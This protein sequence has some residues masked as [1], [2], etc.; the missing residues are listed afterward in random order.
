M[1]INKRIIKG[2]ALSALCIGFAFNSKAQSGYETA[3]ER[4]DAQHQDCMDNAENTTTCS[5]QYFASVDSLVDVVYKDVLKQ[6][7]TKEKTVLRTEQREWLTNK[8]I[9]FR[10]IEAAAKEEGKD[11]E[12]KAD[13]IENKAGHIRERLD[14][15]IGRLK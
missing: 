11:S 15:L 7:E 6:A 12:G 3:L 4:I 1:M 2:F 10:E 14:E 9:K 5:R 13:A 8:S